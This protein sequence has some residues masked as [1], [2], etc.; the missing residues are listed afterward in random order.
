MRRLEGRRIVVTGAASGIGAT[1]ARRFLEEGAAVAMLDRDARSLEAAARE[2]PSTVTLVAD[3]SIP[4][5]VGSAIEAAARMLQGI[6]GLVNA[7][8]VLLPARFEDTELAQWQRMLDV[9]LSG[10][11][12]VCRAALPHLRRGAAATIVNIASGLALRPAANYSAYA[13]SKAG[14]ITL[15]RALAI[16]LAPAIRANV[17]CPGAVETPMTRDLYL[18]PK[19]KAEAMANYALGR[20]ATTSEIANAVLFLT[21]SDS[22]FTTGATLTVDGGRTFH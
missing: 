3:V 18:D 22:S 15:T 12:I 19:R 4:G 11:W 6:D 8:G 13:A 16:E 5:Q 14:L 2:G 20:L 17:V 21:S 7:A 1:I 10:P 9:N